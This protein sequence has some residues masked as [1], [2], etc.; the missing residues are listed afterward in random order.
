MGRWRLDGNDIKSESNSMLHLEGLYPLL[1]HVRHHLPTRYQATPRIFDCLGEAP[2]PEGALVGRALRRI[3][4]PIAKS[5]RLCTQLHRYS[6]VSFFT[7][8]SQY[9]ESI[10]LS[11]TYL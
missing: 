5:K 7:G 10:E 1:P 9:L 11:L 3:G 6:W 8:K 4:K 2:S